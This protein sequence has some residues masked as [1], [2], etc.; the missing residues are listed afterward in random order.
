MP[1]LT[2]HRRI[3]PQETALSSLATILPLAADEQR[4]HAPSIADFF[5]PAILFEGTPFEINRIMIVR[6]IAVVA[7]L[8]DH[9]SSRA[10]R[11]KLVPGRGQIVIEMVLDFVRKCI[12][13]E[14]LGKKMAQ[15]VR[16]RCITTILFAIL[17]LNITGV[18]PVPQHRRDVG[19][20]PAADLRA[21]GVRHCTSSTRC[22]PLGVGGFLKGQLFP[23][24][25]A[26][27]PLH[28]C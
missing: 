9:A 19:D 5:P 13:E 8:T 21:V 12:A 1:A 6:F 11:A 20:R 26:E 25:R 15:E 2:R 10:K 24:G 16:R 4:F 7:L 18:D 17:F 3:R 28:R 22:R 14:I 23:P 27:V